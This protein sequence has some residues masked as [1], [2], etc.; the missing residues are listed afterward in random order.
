M[1]AAFRAREF[2]RSATLC[3]RGEGFETDNLDGSQPGC[4]ARQRSRTARHCTEKTTMPK[5]EKTTTA[6]QCRADAGGRAGPDGAKATSRFGETNPRS[7]AVERF[8]W[9]MADQAKQ[10]WSPG[11]L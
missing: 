1:G 7:S 8:Q 2:R 5:L 3:W 11:K 10:V 6:P 4:A 9:F